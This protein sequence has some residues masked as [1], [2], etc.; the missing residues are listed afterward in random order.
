MQKTLFQ[1][2]KLAHMWSFLTI[3]ILPVLSCIALL[4]TNNLSA[5]RSQ[6]DTSV[7]NGIHHFTNNYMIYTEIMNACTEHLDNRVENGISKAEIPAQLSS[8]EMN[9][10]QVSAIFYFE[11]TSNRIFTSRGEI[12]YSDYERQ[13]Q[14]EYGINLTEMAFYSKLCQ[15]PI[16]NTL[17]SGKPVDGENNRYLFYLRV[18]P[19][20]DSA[21]KSVMVFMLPL[22]TLIE[23]LDEYVPAGYSVYGYSDRYLNYLI[24]KGDG[25]LTAQLQNRLD[26][27]QSDNLTHE[28]ING[29]KYVLLRVKS[30]EDGMYHMIAYRENVLYQGAY[31]IIARTFF[32]VLL[33]LLLTAAIAFAMHR[34]FYKGV[35]QILALPFPAENAIQF[36]D[37]YAYIETNTKQVLNQNRRLVLD[38]RHYNTMQLLQGMLHGS[39]E[40]IQLITSTFEP[41]SIKSIMPRSLFTAAYARGA[42][43]PGMLRDSYF[44]VDMPQLECAFYIISVCGGTAAAILINHEPMNTDMLMNNCAYFLKMEGIEYEAFGMGLAQDKPDMIQMSLMQAQVASQTNEGVR[45]YAPGAQLEGLMPIAEQRKVCQSILAGDADSAVSAFDALMEKLQNIALVS[46]VSH[47]WYVFMLESILVT[48]REGLKA[49]IVAERGVDSMLHLFVGNRDDQFREFIRHLAEQVRNDREKKSIAQQNMIVAYISQHFLEPDLSPARV[50]AAF[51]LTESTVVSALRSTGMTFAK[52][53]AYL[54]MEYVCA[55]LRQTNRPIGEIIAEVGYMDVSNFTRKFR[56]KFGCTPSAYREKTC[57]NKEAL[58]EDAFSLPLHDK[59]GQ[60]NN[61]MGCSPSD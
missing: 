18:L 16:D 29:N 21:P 55:E 22:H 5:Y 59:S 28:T 12:S 34:Y 32:P 20:L 58:P 7:M 53:I 2:T 30:A 41:E 14:T 6:Q 3:S 39:L 9:Y 11:K 25:C 1:K 40:D 50:G 52:Y 44:S 54:K 19:R 35:E 37:P 15:T 10:P 48:L 42:K 27:L 17:V 46:C 26:T 51:N 57:G 33:I 60:K 49:D 38:I 4:C 56:L 31:Q 45:L 47:E 36:K 23:S 13:M 8:Y 43:L 61:S 24:R